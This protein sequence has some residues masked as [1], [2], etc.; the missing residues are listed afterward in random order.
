LDIEKVLFQKMLIENCKLFPCKPFKNN[1]EVKELIES[2]I[3]LKKQNPQAD[4]T[5]IENR[6]D[7]LVYQLYGLTKE[8]NPY[9]RKQ[10]QAWFGL[11]LLTG[12]H[13]NAL[14]FCWFFREF[15][16]TPLWFLHL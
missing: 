10:H 3:K 7:R 1:I 14:L 6:I 5:D 4:T 9:H 12:L 2:I 13:F 8:K 11:N 16:I 15:H